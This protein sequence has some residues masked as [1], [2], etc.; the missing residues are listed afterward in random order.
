MFFISGTSW[1]QC[2]FSSLNAR[3][4]GVILFKLPNLLGIGHFKGSTF[5]IYLDS[6]RLSV[7]DRHLRNWSGSLI[8]MVIAAHWTDTEDH[9]DEENTRSDHDITDWGHDVA[10]VR[11]QRSDATFFWKTSFEWLGQVP[12]GW[13]TK[14]ATLVLIL[15]E[16]NEVFDLAQLIIGTLYRLS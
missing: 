8:R 4:D 7:R 2:S 12:H 10:N 11:N 3:I 14:T 5:L 6:A 15:H 16:L 13:V 9:K 1:S